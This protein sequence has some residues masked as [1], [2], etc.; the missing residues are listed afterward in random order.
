M[1]T[2]IYSLQNYCYSFVTHTVIQL[3]N[4]QV[5]RKLLGGGGGGAH[6]GLYRAFHEECLRRQSLSSS[7]LNVL[8]CL[9]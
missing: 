4:F 7:S 9:T 8:Q 5:F 2:L 3:F 1:Y 6:C